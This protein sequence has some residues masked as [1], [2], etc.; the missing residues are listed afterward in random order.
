MLI[1]FIVIACINTMWQILRA[2]L[3]KFLQEGRGWGESAALYFNSA[4]FVATD[5]GCLGAGFMAVWLTRRGCTVHGARLLVFGT[6]GLLCALCALIPWLPPGWPLGV[7]LMV[8]GA[9]ALGLFPIYHAYT[10]DISGTHQG[11]ITGIASVAAW[12]MPALAQPLFGW[13][14]DRTGSFDA[15]LVAAGFLPL[16][17]GFALAVGWKDVWTKTIP[18]ENP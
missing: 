11:R 2:W 16:L 7:V 10:Q 12:I 3:P 13:L 18:A 5:I 8:I 9:G 14:A 15:G 4:W 17:A 6:C 1:I